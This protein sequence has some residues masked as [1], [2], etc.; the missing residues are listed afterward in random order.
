M[1]HAPI[2][3]AQK[4]AKEVR[5]RLLNPK[6]K[7]RDDAPPPVV[8][9]TTEY[10]PIK[11]KQLLVWGSETLPFEEVVRRFKTNGMM[12]I[13]CEGIVRQ[14]RRTANE[15]IREVLLDF[16][17]YTIEDLKGR[18]RLKSLTLVRHIAMHAVHK[19]RP[20][21][22]FPQIGRLFGGFDHTSVLHAVNRIE[23]MKAKE[24]A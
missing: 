9:R 6:V 19:Q 11:A 2:T 22:S 8:D 12:Q 18:R 10:A 23:A 13:D 24:R 5:D 7:G 3:Q 16:P 15:I 1:M 20:D 17:Q 21:L 4:H 14:P